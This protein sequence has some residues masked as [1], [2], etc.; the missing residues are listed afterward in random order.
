MVKAEK[1]TKVEEEQLQP[2]LSRYASGYSG[3]SDPYLIS[4]FWSFR[5]I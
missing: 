4:S 2:T 3:C 5:N 1:R